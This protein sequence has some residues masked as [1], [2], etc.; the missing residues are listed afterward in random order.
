VDVDAREALGLRTALQWVR[1]LE[2]H[3]VDFEM[4]SQTVVDSVYGKRNMNSEF[5]AIVTDCCH[6]LTSDLITFQVRFIRRQAND[7]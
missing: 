3:D 4:D 1:D 5:G 7:S 2:L 6:L